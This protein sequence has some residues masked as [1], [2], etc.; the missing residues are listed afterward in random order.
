MLLL[1]TTTI[2]QL[3]FFHMLKHSNFVLKK[4]DS[5]V[6]DQL[7]FGRCAESLEIVS[8]ISILEQQFF[9]MVVFLVQTCS[10]IG[11]FFALLH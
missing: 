7:Y 2:G 11:S 3:L 9:C 6:I 1:A 4:I 8:R 5:E 10:E